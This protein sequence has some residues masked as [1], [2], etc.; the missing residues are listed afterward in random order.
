MTNAELH[1]EVQ[2]LRE[3]IAR[4]RAEVTAGRAYTF[5]IPAN[6]H[7]CPGVMFSPTGAVPALNIRLD[8]GAAACAP[9]PSIVTFPALGK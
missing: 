1:R 4:L 2:E 9:G 8:T 3:E 7:A 5:P 6:A